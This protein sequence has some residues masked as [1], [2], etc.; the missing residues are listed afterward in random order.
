[1]K[2]G[3]VVFPGSNCDQDSFYGV[4]SVMGAEAELIWH[5]DHKV[6]QYDCIILPGGFS[7]GDYLR[8]GSIARY[9]PVMKEVIAFA[10]DG[11][12]VLGIC[13]GFQVLLESNLLPGAMLQ[14]Q[15]VHFLCKSVYM[16]T[17]HS[18]TP[19]TNAIK[20]GELLKIPIAHMD[21]NYYCDDS[22]YQRLKGNSQILFTYCDATGNSTEG[23]NP[24]GSLGNIA[25]I[26]N[27]KRNV[28][29]LMPHPERALESMLGSEDGKK[30]FESI[31]SHC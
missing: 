12:L 14:N 25:G 23:A 8:A 1:M 31:N 26:C 20:K 7:Y 16:K 18:N 30:I 13:N 21:G 3:I 11:G 24:N 28:L 5:E 17:H 2:Y 6:G 15:H 9:A 22:T 19:Y 4:T 27:E 29:G 10:N